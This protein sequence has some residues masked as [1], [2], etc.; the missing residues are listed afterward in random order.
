MLGAGTLVEINKKSRRTLCVTGEVIC[1]SESRN[2]FNLVEK[3]EAVKTYCRALW[4]KLVSF[5]QLNRRLTI[6]YFVHV[7]L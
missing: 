5:W 1:I 3:E 2:A 7:K 6:V 4:N